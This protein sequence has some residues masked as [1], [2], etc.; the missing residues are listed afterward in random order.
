MADPALPETYNQLPDPLKQTLVT[1]HQEYVKGWPGRPFADY[2]NDLEAGGYLAVIS[3]VHTRCAKDAKL[4]PFIQT[5]IG[6]WNYAQG[7]D[8]SQGF[9]FLCDQ[10]EALLKHLRGSSLF[11]EDDPSTTVHGPRDCF[12]EIVTAGSG[13]HVCVVR[14]DARQTHRHDIHIDKHQA[15]C[16]RKTDGFC[17]YHY[18]NT[19]FVNHMKDVVPWFLTDVAPKK[20]REAAK[21]VGEAAEKAAKGYG[22]RESRRYGPKY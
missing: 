3:A 5:V 8:I 16:T 4:W 15:V 10:P 7:H 14:P 9:N 11:C 1:S 6:P 20:I 19:N 12:R 22:E 13:L 21:A 18:L 17:D 2:I